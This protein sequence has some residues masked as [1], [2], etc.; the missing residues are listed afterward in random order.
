MQ[1][2]WSVGDPI[3]VYPTVPVSGLNKA[4]LH[5]FAGS[6]LCIAS[7]TIMQVLTAITERLMDVDEKVRSGAI[8]AICDTAVKNL[9]VRL[10]AFSKPLV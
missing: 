4:L 7:I 10:L 6:D 2:L 9:Q 5:T 1:S 8:A 3:P